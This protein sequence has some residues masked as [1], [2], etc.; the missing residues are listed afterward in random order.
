MD[1]SNY[2]PMKELLRDKYF[3]QGELLLGNDLMKLFSLRQ[4]VFLIDSHLL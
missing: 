3:D 4:L 1:V 2:Y